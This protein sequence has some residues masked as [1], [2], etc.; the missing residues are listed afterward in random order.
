M[1]VALNDI[2]AEDY[3]LQTLKKTKSSEIETTL[4]V[5]D[6]EYVKILL[7][8]LCKFITESREIELCIRCA[9]FLL[10]YKQLK[11]KNIKFNHFKLRINFGQISTTQS[12]LPLVEQLRDI[13]YKQGNRIRDTIGFNLS[14]VKFLKQKVEENEQIRLFS[15]VSSKYKEKTKKRQ[16]KVALISLKSA[17]S[18]S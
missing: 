18:V 2:N 4:L 12:M 13:C 7:Q 10:K 1:L 5:L 14:A 3:V 17:S 11:I 15:D 16:K 8:L 6:Y 9:I